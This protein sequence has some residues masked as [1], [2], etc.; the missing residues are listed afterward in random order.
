VK[1]PL[2]LQG[3]YSEAKNKMEDLLDK[4]EEKARAFQIRE[5]KKGMLGLIGWLDRNVGDD[6]SE[7][8][9]EA[10]VRD[11]DGSLEVIV[12]QER[13]GKFFLL[14]LDDEFGGK[15]I[16]VL[17]TPDSE[18]CF[19]LAGCKVALPY[20]FSA[21]WQLEKTIEELEKDNRCRLPSCWQESS[22]LAGEL[23]LILDK[24]NSAALFG[25]KLT[26]DNTLGLRTGA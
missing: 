18:M 8:K 12:I 19:A 26:Y 21:H 16:P 3:E 11:T 10:T 14:P 24:N 17:N 2:E 7:K 9:S 4:K 5:P 13:N 25:K 23:F 6:G 1:M 15:E 22:W 20:P